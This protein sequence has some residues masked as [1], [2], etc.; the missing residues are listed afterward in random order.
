MKLI[1]QQQGLTFISIVIILGLI[2]FFSLMIM[3]ISPHYM[4]SYKVKRGVD[5]LSE[6]SGIEQEST[7]R[8][9]SLLQKRWDIEDIPLDTVHTRNKDQVKVKKEGGVIKVTVEYEKRF[10]IMSNLDGVAVFKFE[11]EMK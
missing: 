4:E 3:K 6:I 8:I 7:K 11:N 1:K 5:S 9:K 2:A 10:N